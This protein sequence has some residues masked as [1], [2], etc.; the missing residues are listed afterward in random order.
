MNAQMI[1]KQFNWFIIDMIFYID[2]SILPYYSL[3]A[4]GPT[5]QHRC[6]IECFI[7]FVWFHNTRTR[8]YFVPSHCERSMRR[9][10]NVMV[11]GLLEMTNE[12][13]ESTSMWGNC[14]AEQSRY[15][16]VPLNVRVCGVCIQ[17][18]MINRNR[19]DL[20]RPEYNIVSSLETLHYT[21][22]CSLS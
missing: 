9:R 10:L 8:T 15:Y 12:P 14:L 4:N 20:T 21:R 7:F 16:L 11:I 3:G 6:L 5:I 2:K 13:K 18:K 19:N 17:W 1:D 22:F